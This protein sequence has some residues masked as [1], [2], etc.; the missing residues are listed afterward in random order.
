MS[1]R[2]FKETMQQQPEI[3]AFSIS[4]GTGVERLIKANEFIR[5]FRN[6]SD[7][8]IF[9]G[10]MHTAMMSE[11]LKEGKNISEKDADKIENPVTFMI[12]PVVF[13]NDGFQS[14]VPDDIKKLAIQQGN[15]I[16]LTPAPSL[17]C[18]N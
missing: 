16:E 10:N 11:N 3:K 8:V 4:G 12:T 9:A 18:G 7:Y 2:F 6:Q 1:R 15:I 5:Q 17:Q 13:D 14:G